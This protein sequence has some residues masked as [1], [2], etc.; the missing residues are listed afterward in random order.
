YTPKEIAYQ[1]NDSH[2]RTLFVHASFL[3][4]ALE[5]S[6]LL[7]DNHPLNTIVVVDSD[8]STNLSAEGISIH[9]YE[10]LASAENI[11]F[12]RID[13]DPKHDIALLPYSSGTTGRPKG[14][15]LTH[16]NLVANVTQVVDGEG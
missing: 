1:L 10:D 7:V 9:R 5:A 11:L 13:V 15:V 16:E 3:E 6:K 8:S 2:A 12:P 14:V 4:K